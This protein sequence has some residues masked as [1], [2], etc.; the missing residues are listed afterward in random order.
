MS[1]GIIFWGRSSRF[2]KVFILQKKII[3]IMTNTRPRDSYREVFRKMEIMTVYSQYIYSLLLFKINNRY[4]FNTNNEIQKYKTRVSCN[5]HLPAVNLT[6]F[7]K[8]AY[9]SGIK[10]FNH[11]P[12]SLQILANDDKSFTSTLK[13][14]LKHHSFYST[15]EYYQFM[16]DEGVL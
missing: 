4:L 7:H 12:Q 10:V 13:K 2:H 6:K 14:F 5:L 8:G 11:L 9:I 15:H 1:Y 3:R 16:E